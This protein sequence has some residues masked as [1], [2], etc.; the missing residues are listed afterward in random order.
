MNLKSIIHTISATLWLVLAFG[1]CSDGA[2]SPAPTIW[3]GV[4]SIAL[5]FPGGDV[6][7][8]QFS[9]L[10]AGSG[11]VVLA[12]DL[13]NIDLVNG[14]A[15]LS[16]ALP[17]G[18]Y[19]LTGRLAC[20][21]PTDVLT[22]EGSTEDFTVDG[23]WSVTWRFLG[24]GGSNDLGDITLRICPKPTLAAVIP[25]LVCAETNTQISATVL[26]ARAPGAN[27][28]TTVALTLG[29]AFIEAT[30]PSDATEVQASIAAP[31]AIGTE[32]LEMSVSVGDDPFGTIGSTQIETAACGVP[33]VPQ[34][35]CSIT[36]DGVVIG[37][38]V[39][40]GDQL[41]FDV[42]VGDNSVAML[43]F[44][45]DA[46]ENEVAFGA[47]TPLTILEAAGLAGSSTFLQAKPTPSSLTFIVSPDVLAGQEV[48]S[49]VT[50]HWVRISATLLGTSPTVDLHITGVMT[51]LDGTNL[52]DVPFD[53]IQ[54]LE[55]AP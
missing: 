16:L 9:A 17:S 1:A 31:S 33:V 38:P 20:T 48:A 39:V 54:T 50:G 18:D 55:V 12:A 26:L 45:G 52:T 32:P 34:E 27:C 2:P 47:A 40:N 37:C 24:E 8:H 29:D 51:V 41:T 7:C 22:L 35:P 14:V 46:D 43:S 5:D 11:E 28:P 4:A 10:N 25:T 21:T 15:K 23:P 53:T 3:P 6:T 42:A 36:G 44:R 13:D 49:V 30:I 19:S